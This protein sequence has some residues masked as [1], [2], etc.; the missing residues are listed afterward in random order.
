MLTAMILICSL[1]NTT[2]LSDCSQNNARAV[3]W[4]PETFN[5]PVTCFLHG[6]A[7]IAGTAFG[8]DLRS[9]ERIRILCR[10]RGAAALPNESTLAFRRAPTR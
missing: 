10:P 8:R 5:N 6:Q 7:Y 3:L 4:V 9:G 1:T 2:N